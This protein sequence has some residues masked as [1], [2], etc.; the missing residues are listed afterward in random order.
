MSPG[1][2][3]E[4]LGELADACRVLAREGHNDLTLGHLSLRDPDGRGFWLKKP[5]RGLDEIAGAGDFHLLGWEGG[6]D[7]GE[8]V[9]IEWPIHAGVLQARP[10]LQVVGHTHPYWGH[11]ASCSAEPLRLIGNEG[12]A[13]TSGIP[14]FSVTPDLIRS[15]ALGRDVA[16]ALGSARA[17][18]LTHHGVVFGGASVAEAVLTGLWLERLCRSNLLVG[19]SASAVRV[20]VLSEKAARTFADSAVRQH[21]SYLRRTLP[22]R[23]GS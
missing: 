12:A 23:A 6:N 9:H 10:D 18:L 8:P 5:G 22:S 16:H 17:A 11:L 21:W 19:G 2:P 7:S 4:E 20:N 1:T 14:M 13:F 3:S 15:A